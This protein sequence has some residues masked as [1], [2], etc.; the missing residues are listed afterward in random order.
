MKK[1]APIALFTYKKLEPLKKVIKALESNRLA[2]ASDLFIFSDA[3]KLKK[4]EIAVSQVR[5]FL[6][7]I[8][9]FKT[10]T[11]KTAEVNRGLAN[12]IINGVSQ[13]LGEN[14]TV[15][16]ME[17]DLTSS[18]NF[19]EFMN[20]AL[21]FYSSYSNVFSIAGYTPPIKLNN[22]Y[23]YDVYFTR[24]ASSW[25]WATWKKQWEGVDWSVTDYN[26]FKDNRKQQRRF[27][28]MGSDM[29][30]MLLKQKAGKSDSWAIRWCYHQFQHNL[31]TV[32]P[33]S[34]KIQNIGFLDDA[35][36]TK[37]KNTENRFFTIIDQENKS[38]FHFDPEVTLNPEMIKQFVKPYNLLTR[39]RYKIKDLIH[40]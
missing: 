3:A 6:K 38:T 10:I 4:D 12:S 21:D 40:I 9:G 28:E 26:E 2:K 1:L 11:I 7:T 20:A 17:D 37:S 36:H 39:L 24:R 25:G 14:D 22:G 29:T 8:T 32:F 13:L 27:N 35:T 5:S 34:S 18:V 15:I 30:S 16:V 33:C 31:L 23:P 19:L